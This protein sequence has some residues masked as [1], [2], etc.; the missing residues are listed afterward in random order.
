MKPAGCW[1]LNN[2]VRSNVVWRGDAPSPTGP[3]HAG[4]RAEGARGGWI[5]PDS[6]QAD[7]P[8]GDLR[9]A[10]DNTCRYGGW[11]HTASNWIAAAEADS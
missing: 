9:A 6:D 10:L 8:S 1:W 4:W 3:T 7:G 11:N 5:G 2:W